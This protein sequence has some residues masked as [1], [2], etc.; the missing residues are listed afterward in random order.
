M[1][2]MCGGCGE[3]PAN[4]DGMCWPCMKRLAREQEAEV[5]EQARVD[6]IKDVA[7]L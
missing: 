7:A 5:R 6:I 4:V 3:R 1:M 2:K